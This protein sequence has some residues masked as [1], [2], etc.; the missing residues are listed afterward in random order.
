MGQLLMWLI[1][2][3]NSKIKELV[4]MQKV[5]RFLKLS[6]NVNELV[7]QDIPA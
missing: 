4:L 2:K 6:S 7:I 1:L 5:L 3:I